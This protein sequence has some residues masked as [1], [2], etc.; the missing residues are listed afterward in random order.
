MMAAHIPPTTML[1]E[2]FSINHLEEVFLHE[3][4]M[5]KFDPYHVL[6]VDY[7]ERGNLTPGQLRQRIRTNFRTYLDRII[8][9]GVNEAGLLDFH[10]SPVFDGFLRK[11]LADLGPTPSTQ[12]LVLYAQSNGPKDIVDYIEQQGEEGGKQ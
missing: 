12:A 11:V 4:I 1:P 7:H 3:V 10:R 2:E 9:I 8:T 5:A 6:G